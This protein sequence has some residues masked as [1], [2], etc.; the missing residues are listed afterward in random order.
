MTSDSKVDLLTNGTKCIPLLARIIVLL[1]KMQ[2]TI[3]IDQM[4]AFRLK[5]GSG[6]KMGLQV[7]TVIPQVENGMYQFCFRLHINNGPLGK[8]NK[9]CLKI[10]KNKLYI[11]D[12]TMT[13][14]QTIVHKA[15][16]R[17]LKIERHKPQ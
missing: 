1:R 13:K 11:T 8:N 14:R 10:L 2:G 15:L 17:K 6:I 9:K 12:N 7:D 4:T 5:S 16:H 3:G